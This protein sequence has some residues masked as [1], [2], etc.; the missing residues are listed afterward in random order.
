MSYPLL[1]L[2]QVAKQYGEK[3][4][5]TDISLDLH[6][7]E[8]VSLL[9]VNGAG[10]TTLS[11]IIATLHP[12]TYGDI[13]FKGSSIN[14]NLSAY[15]DHVGYCQ[16]EANLHPQLTVEE[17]LY[18]AGK[19]Y[20]L[21]SQKIRQRFDELHEQLGIG[22]YRTYY[23]SA[24]SGGWKQRCMIARC[25]IH[26]PSLVIFDEPTVALDLDVRNQL[27]S[28]IRMLRDKGTCVLLTTHYLEEAETLSDRV[29]V[30]HRGKIQITD[31]PSNLMK[32][33]EKGKLEEVFLQLTDEAKK[34]DE[35]D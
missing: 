19:Y 30:L 1:A 24:L 5:L 6:R 7:G 10:K 12:P 34:N 33:F 35:T 17:S 22:D 29:C 18:F 31:T 9:G 28:Y 14:N 13:F 20:G 3:P 32:N 2:R 25:L 26:E 27:W 16:Q 23:P 21:S 8:V 11:T 15:R 4:V